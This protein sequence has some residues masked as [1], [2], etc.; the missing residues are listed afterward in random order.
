MDISNI[1][2]HLT[3]KNQQPLILKRYPS[4]FRAELTQSNSLYVLKLNQLPE[5]VDLEYLIIMKPNTPNK[6]MNFAIDNQHSARQEFLSHVQ[7]AFN[8]QEKVFTFMSKGGKE[9]NSLTWEQLN[10]RANAIANELL[11]TYGLKAGDRVLLVYPP[12]LDFIEALLACFYAGIIAV[13]A[14]LPDHRGM[15]IINKIALD[16]Q[17]SL[18][19]T[20]A[21]Y[22]VYR[23]TAI[24][25][26][27]KAHLFEHTE[28]ALPWIVPQSDTYDHFTP[29]ITQT[30]EVAFLQ[31]TSGSTSHPKGVC[32]NWSNLLHQLE[33]NKKHLQQSFSSRMVMWI[34]HF[35][36]L[37]LIGGIL[38]CM[39][40]N[41]ALWFMSPLSF[42]R[43][44]SVWMELIHKVRATHTA[45]PDFAYKLITQKTTDEQRKHWDLSCLQFCLNAAEPIQASTL[46]NFLDTFQ[47][48]NLNP[49][50]SS[51]SY[52]LAEHTIGVTVNGKQ[53]INID[54]AQLQQQQIMITNTDDNHS[55]TLVG[56]G[57]IT[58]DIDV[59]IVN[60]NTHILCK[61]DE[62][63]E[64]WIDSPSKANGYWK[65]EAL[66]T[67]IFKAEIIG[68]SQNKTYLRTG[69]LGF[70]YQNE[71]FI[72][73]RLK[74]V[75]IINGKNIYPQDIEYL[76]E[77]KH[78][79]IRSSRI[80][81]FSTKENTQEI[82]NIALE[83]E[84]DINIDEVK[85]PLIKS[86]PSLVWQQESVVVGRIIFMGRGSIPKTTSG[87]VQRQT[88]KIAFEENKIKYLAL[89]E[90]PLS[91]Q[92]LHPIEKKDNIIIKNNSQHSYTFY[93]EKE[94]ALWM[95][96]RISQTLECSPEDVL[97]N[98][99]FYKY[100]LDSIASLQLI[101]EIERLFE[102]PIPA[103]LFFEYT[104]IESVSNFLY[105]MQKK[106][107]IKNKSKKINYD[108]S[109]NESIIYKMSKI[110]NPSAY[111]INLFIKVN[112]NLNIKKTKENIRNII[113]R[114]E[115]LRSKYIEH[116]GKV[117][118]S[119]VK[120]IK[121][122]ISFHDISKLPSL[123][124]SSKEKALLLESQNKKFDLKKSN[125]LHFHIIKKSSL[126][127]LLLISIHHIISDFHSLSNI[128]NE[129]LN[130]DE[131]NNSKLSNYNDDYI[132]YVKNEK[133]RY[134]SK[135]SIRNLLYWDSIL[136]NQD[137]YE[138]YKFSGNFC[139]NENHCLER[140]FNINTSSNKALIKFSKTNNIPYS[141]LLLS[142]YQISLI[143]ITGK[144]SIYLRLP[145][146]NRQTLAS[147][148]MQGYLAYGVPCFTNIIESDKIS[149]V[150]KFNNK[151]ILNQT[152]FYDFQ[153][154]SM[155]YSSDFSIPKPTFEFNYISTNIIEDDKVEILESS[156]KKDKMWERNYY[157][158]DFSLSNIKNND[159]LQANI[160]YRK[161]FVP[162]Y[163]IEDFIGIYNKVLE[164][165][166]SNLD[167]S[168]TDFKKLINE[169]NNNEKQKKNNH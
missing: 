24:N 8:N 118:R 47:S 85:T 86:I 132:D 87:K 169:S 77:K 117:S 14:A 64:I 166:M 88:C 119:T 144:K 99:E 110:S 22:N 40:G 76:I 141:T 7:S 4:S 5:I 78:K 58:D 160:C 80:I 45:A 49:N 81:A 32:I 12:S 16:C 37:G 168:F 21:E 60:P 151:N 116:H 18:V 164:I 53:R 89:W 39:Y 130:H 59:A 73:G 13:P 71:L 67:E 96:E 106:D 66:S 65:M 146:S 44:P 162:K 35:H 55:H 152:Y 36:D 101:D 62:V 82:L 84:N 42:I 48:S 43:N 102:I 98:T 19:L 137:R 100:N 104:S 3:I 167:I 51:P 111:N 105:K 9:S 121:K 90:N 46:D 124:K 109:L 138:K 131:S 70:I 75:I 15:S 140:R 11:Y 52:G 114:N 6:A 94:I 2:H 74:D 30:T 79:Q 23:L 136:N 127:Y 156:Y 17:P 133:T 107:N 155:L 135:D 123:D 1:G 126:E 83:I 57:E 93:R 165:I 143:I 139:E 147:K 92:K 61:K 68:S 163:F 148:S 112:K 142:I 34:P 27:K 158:I 69:D 103:D 25:S 128:V 134:L 153:I 41:G 38:S 54:K 161:K 129:I 97:I 157:S 56:C 113:D 29:E 10:G 33:F 108:L 72:T 91:T 125:L 149:N 28:M 120:N 95:Q 145:F 154:D 115:I 20:N 63:G 122:Y 26:N 159:N 50:T 31:Y 150:L